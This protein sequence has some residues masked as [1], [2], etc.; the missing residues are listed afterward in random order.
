MT[1]PLDAAGKAIWFPR[2]SMDCECME[3]GRKT[4]KYNIEF[5]NLRGKLTQANW[6][7]ALYRA[8]GLDLAMLRNV[9]KKVILNFGH[10]C[11]KRV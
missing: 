3:I 9:G 5:R 2:N 8:V 11:V 7:F 1:M 10:H 4:S 6:K